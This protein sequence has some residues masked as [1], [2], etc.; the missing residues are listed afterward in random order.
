MNAPEVPNEAQ[1]HADVH[2]N[3]DRVV[4]AQLPVGAN[5]QHGPAVMIPGLLPHRH[6]LTCV[7]TKGILALHEVAKIRAFFRCVQRSS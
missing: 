6:P 1:V 7:Q 2:R 3:G 5:P 4:L